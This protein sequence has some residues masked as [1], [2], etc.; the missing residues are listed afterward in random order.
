[1]EGENEKSDNIVWVDCEMSGLDP[2]TDALLEVAVVIT[3]KNMNV[4]CIG[5]N[6]VI[7]QNEDVLR[8]M[9]QWCIEHHGMSGLTQQV[10]ESTITLK[11]AERQIVRVVKQWTKKGKC[12]LAGNSIGQDAKFLDKYMPDLMS[13]LHYRIIDVSTVK[14]LC[15]RKNPK[16]FDSKPEKKLAHRALD[17]IMESIEELKYYTENFFI[18]E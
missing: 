17:D 15:R 1:M 2:K 10:R 3:D 13:Q 7:H 16:V 6:I 12:P 9:N 8:N 14:E 18:T 5:P 4:L 11:E